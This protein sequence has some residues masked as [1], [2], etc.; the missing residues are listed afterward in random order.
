MA[1]IFTD[2][3]NS[4]TDGNLVGQGS[5]TEQTSASN[6]D[7]QGTVVK[8]GAKAAFLTN[9]VGGSAPIIYKTGSAIDTGRISFYARKNATNK[10]AL[11]TV[12]KISSHE[13]AIV[14]FADDGNIQYFNGSTYVTIQAYSTDT[15]YGVEIEWRVSDHKARYRINVGTWTDWYAVNGSSWTSFDSMRVFGNNNGTDITYFD[16]IS[17]YSLPSSSFFLMF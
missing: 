6:F 14:K 13:G 10:E 5:W 17:E 4:Y 15:W 7:I 16:Y 11:F 12:E 2:N 8:E 3:F 9:V 1:T